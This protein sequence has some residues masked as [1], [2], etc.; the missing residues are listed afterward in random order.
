MNPMTKEFDD[1]VDE[2]REFYLKLGRNIRD[3]RK[4]RGWS[5]RKL[6]SELNIPPNSLCNHE[7]G[8]IETT[9]ARLQEIARIL[10]VSPTSLLPI[11]TLKLPSIP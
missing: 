1:R 3:I 6:A 4:Q 8:R 9:T 11:Q 2:R 10:S 7:M 5:Q